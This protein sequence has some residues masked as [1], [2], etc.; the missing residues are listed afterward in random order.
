MTSPR[1]Y[2]RYHGKD[3]FEERYVVI[4]SR[5]GDEVSAPKLYHLANDEAGQRNDG[6]FGAL[7]LGDWV[8]GMNLMP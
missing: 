1:F 3:G 8:P 5:T 2:A 4:D 6:T 7:T